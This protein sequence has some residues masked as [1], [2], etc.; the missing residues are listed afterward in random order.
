MNGQGGSGSHG[1]IA[2]DRGD[3]VDEVIQGDLAGSWDVLADD[4]CAYDP[5]GRWSM[6]ARSV[7][8]SGPALASALARSSSK[9]ASPSNARNA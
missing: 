6:M 2:A 5:G 8:R 7:D 4:A 3:T 9:F 1:V